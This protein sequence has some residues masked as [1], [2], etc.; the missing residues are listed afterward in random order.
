MRAAPGHA[1][2]LLTSF[3]RGTEFLATGRCGD[4]L[5]FEMPDGTAFVP[6]ALGGVELLVPAAGAAAS[7]EGAADGATPPPGQAAP[8]RNPEGDAIL[9]NQVQLRS[10][11][12]WWE[13]GNG[14]KAARAHPLL[15]L[16]EPAMLAEIVEAG[17]NYHTILTPDR[18]DGLQRRAGAGGGPE[19]ESLRKALIIII[20]Y[21]SYYTCMC[22]YIYIYIYRFM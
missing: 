2:E 6:R 3:P 5:R 1:A 12:A 4:Y 17:A 11:M 18:L 16:V 22:V 9:Q 13:G 15:S 7:P 8:A 14:A 19:L 20:S 21:S 10:F